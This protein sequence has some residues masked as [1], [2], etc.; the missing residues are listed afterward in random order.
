M[1]RSWEVP[2][3]HEPDKPYSGYVQYNEMN[4]DNE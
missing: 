4:K 2:L 3:M 1:Y